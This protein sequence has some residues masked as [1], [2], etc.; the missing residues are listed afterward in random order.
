VFDDFQELDE[1]LMVLIL[2]FI[3]IIERLSNKRLLHARLLLSPLFFPCGEGEWKRLPI[4]STIGEQ[5]LPAILVQH[6][7]TSASL[8][9]PSPSFCLKFL[10]AER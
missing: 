7:R 1:S 6:D 5:K 9:P 2:F 4:N 3:T 10:E 8:S